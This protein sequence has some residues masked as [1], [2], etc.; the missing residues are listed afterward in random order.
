[1]QSEQDRV[2][3]D[4][5]ERAP[6]RG[7]HPLF[8][9]DRGGHLVVDIGRRTAE[10]LIAAGVLVAAFALINAAAMEAAKCASAPCKTFGD[11]LYVA[12]ITLS[13]SVATMAAS[14]VVFAFPAGFPW[15]ASV[16]GAI[17]FTMATIAAV[18]LFYISASVLR[19]LDTCL[20]AVPSTAVTVQAI[21]GILAAI[22]I[23]GASS[24][25]SIILFGAA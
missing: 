22:A 24:R 21:V 16:I 7:D 15:G 10:M 4:P 23:L 6:G 25:G 2:A 18:T 1:V 11:R 17:F 9:R 20:A 3:A 12:L 13:V 5:S 14:A 8:Q 19:Q